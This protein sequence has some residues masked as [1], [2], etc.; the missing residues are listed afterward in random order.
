[1]KMRFI[2][3]YDFFLSKSASS[4]SRSQAHLAKR[5]RIEWSIGFNSWTNW[6][7]HGVIPGSLCKIRLNDVPLM[8]NYLKRWWIDVDGV[9]HTLFLSFHIHT[10]QTYGADGASLLPKSVCCFRIHECP[11]SLVGSVLDYYCEGRGFDYHQRLW[12]VTLH[13]ANGRSYSTRIYN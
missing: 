2:W 5:K 4:V 13:R 1:M 8:F 10:L 6:T 7:L 9:S 12:S 3:K 11:G